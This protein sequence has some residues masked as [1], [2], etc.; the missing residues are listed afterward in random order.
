[1]KF[2]QLRGFEKHLEGTDLTHFSS[3]YV[4][5]GKESFQRK[6]AVDKLLDKLFPNKEDRVLHLRFYESEQI[7]TF[8]LMNELN[9]MALFSGRQVIV[10]NNAEK[11]EKSLMGEL[12]KYFPH[13]NPSVCLVISAS[14]INKNTNFYKMAEKAG[15]IL[16]FIEEKPKDKEVSAIAWINSYVSSNNKRIDASALHLLVKL[17]G[18]EQSALHSEL[19]K[20]ICYVGDRPNISSLDISKTITAI[21][22]DNCWDLS[23]AVLLRDAAASLRISKALLL[24]GTAFFALLRML[25]TQFQTELQ[26]ASI[27][28]RGGGASEITAHFPY[29]K[30]FI[31]ERHMAMAKN[32]GFKRLK[33][34]LLKIDDTELQAK[35]SSLDH[36][37]LAEQLIIKLTI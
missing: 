1:M 13:P 33:L 3:L 29:M 15:I 20:L 11:L 4:I 35:N 25:R 28:E 27:M 10:L 17:L 12:E 23:E 30:G 2:V 8:I 7:S 26:V 32:Y 34:A 24:E 37:L 36:F 21:N 9:G 16:D 18:Y 14:A 19:E 31:L 6:L 22:N 5:V